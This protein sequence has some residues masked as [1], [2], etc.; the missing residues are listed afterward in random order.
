MFGRKKI[1]A[2]E[3]ALSSAASSIVEM[4]KKNDLLEGRIKEVEKRFDDYTESMDENAEN[5]ER[6]M[7]KALKSILGI[8]FG[9][10]NAE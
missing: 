3:A 5:A 1:A 2:L 9:G 8:D 4:G 10:G 6:E 7:N